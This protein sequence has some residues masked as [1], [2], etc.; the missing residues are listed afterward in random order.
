MMMLLTFVNQQRKPS[1]QVCIVSSIITIVPNMSFRI[2]VRQ[3]LARAKHTSAT[4]AQESSIPISTQYARLAKQWPSDPLRPTAQ[5]TS[6]L[7]H[8]QSLFESPS[9]ASPDKKV[10][11]KMS[12]EEEELETKRVN[13]LAEL[14]DDRAATRVRKFPVFLSLSKLIKVESCP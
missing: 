7:A 4:V 6:L 12:P 11:M 8:R 5:F 14:L 13:A 1:K 2:P 9:S 10:P 3:V